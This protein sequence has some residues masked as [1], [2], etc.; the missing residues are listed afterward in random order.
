MRDFNRRYGN[1][2]IKTDFDNALW[3]TLTIVDFYLVF[4]N[5]SLI[6]NY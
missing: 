3:L 6:T 2:K 4:L 1:N 5:N